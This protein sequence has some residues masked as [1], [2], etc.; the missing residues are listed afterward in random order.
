MQALP[1]KKHARPSYIWLFPFLGTAKS[2]CRSYFA[3]VWRA[4]EQTTLRILMFVA[5]QKLKTWYCHSWLFF[6]LGLNTVY[7]YFF[8][9]S[10]AKNTLIIYH[11]LRVLSMLLL[12]GF[13]EAATNK[14]T[15]KPL[16]S[17][18]DQ[19]VQPCQK[20]LKSL[21]SAFLIGSRF[22]QGHAAGS[23]IWP[24]WACSL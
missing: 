2:T 14:T 9:Q 5:P 20:W 23:S 6:Q 11:H 12:F 15:K 7:L 18:D 3:P 22:G 10:P 1:G 13:S 4:L 24:G 21:G 17:Y 8:W 16:V 19:A